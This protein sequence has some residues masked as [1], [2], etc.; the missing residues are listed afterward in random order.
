LANA[1]VGVCVGSSIDIAALL[2]QKLAEVFDVVVARAFLLL[3]EILSAQ[4]QSGDANRQRAPPRGGR[5][6]VVCHFLVVL[7]CSTAPLQVLASAMG[8]M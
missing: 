8:L 2:G 5:A 6:S 7:C 3:E 4:L 1:H